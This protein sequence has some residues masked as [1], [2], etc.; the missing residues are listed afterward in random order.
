MPQTCRSQYPL[1]PAQLGGFLPFAST[2]SGDK[3]API[4][5]VRGTG[6]EPPE[7]T[8][9]SNSVPRSERAS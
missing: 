4:P 2:R 5:A 7:L 6:I 9:S 3:V 8:Q 1:G